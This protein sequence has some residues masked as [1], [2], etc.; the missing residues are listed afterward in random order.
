MVN[1]LILRNVITIYHRC[2]K[3]HFEKKIWLVSKESIQHFIVTK[4]ERIKILTLGI[5]SEISCELTC[6]VTLILYQ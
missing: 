2:A 3:E 1:K 5:R 6:A 4:L